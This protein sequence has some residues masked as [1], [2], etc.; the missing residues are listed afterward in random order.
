M[1]VQ[2]ADAQQQGRR[3]LRELSHAWLIGQRGVS[4]NQETAAAAARRVTSSGTISPS[5]PPITA[6]V[7]R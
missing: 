1:S 4:L 5:V 6:A 2:K 7:C 3:N